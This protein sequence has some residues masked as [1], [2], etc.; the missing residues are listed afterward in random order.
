[1]GREVSRWA[2]NKIEPAH[3]A[4][5]SMIRKSSYLIC[6]VAFTGVLIAALPAATGIGAPFAHETSATQVN[7]AAKGDLLAAPRSIAVKKAP[8]QTPAPRQP[9]ATEQSKRE[10]MDGCESAFS[11]VTVPTMAHIAGRCVG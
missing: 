5:G 10:I 11:P 3:M 6:G 2:W 8:V 1:M 4:E 7:R 9:A